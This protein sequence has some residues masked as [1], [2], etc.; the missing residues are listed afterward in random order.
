MRGGLFDE[1]WWSVLWMARIAP[2]IGEDCVPHY[3]RAHEMMPHRAEPLAGLEHHFRS[4]GRHN[5]ACTFGVLASTKPF[6]VD[7]ASF[8][9]LNAYSDDALKA[10]GIAA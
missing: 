10:A 6:P 1:A 3:L 7:A 5:A 2:F 4:T 8:V 9:D